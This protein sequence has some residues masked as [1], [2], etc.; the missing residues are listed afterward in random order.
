MLSSFN[1]GEVS[2]LN[3]S[4]MNSQSWTIFYFWQYTFIFFVFIPFS[5]SWVTKYL[6]CESLCSSCTRTEI[7]AMI[8]KKNM[9]KLYM[10]H[11]RG[12]LVYCCIVTHKDIYFEGKSFH[13]EDEGGGTTQSCLHAL[14][15]VCAFCLCLFHFNMPHLQVNLEEKVYLPVFQVHASMCAAF[16]PQCPP[17]PTYVFVCCLHGTRMNN[18]HRCTKVQFTGR[19]T[20][21]HMAKITSSRQTLDTEKLLEST[22][23]CWTGL[24]P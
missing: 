1:N 8:I 7:I 9:T 21:Y 5:C 6:E 10:H 2:R 14:S 18:P 22:E 20:R 23:S 4:V 13:W 24:S 15:T 19:F 16:P 17:P 11:F 3:V 12:G